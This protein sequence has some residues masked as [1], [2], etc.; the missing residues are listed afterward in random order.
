LAMLSAIARMTDFREEWVRGGDVIS[1]VGVGWKGGRKAAG[2]GALQVDSGRRE[3]NASS[4]RR[5]TM[6]GQFAHF[7]HETI[8]DA[9]KKC[10]I[11]TSLAVQRAQSCKNDQDGVFEGVSDPA[12]HRCSQNRRYQ[13]RRQ[14][15]TDQYRQ[16]ATDAVS[17]GHTVSLRSVHAG[18]R[19]K[20]D[21]KRG[22]AYQGPGTSAT[23]DRYESSDSRKV[24]NAEPRAH[25]Q[26][27]GWRICPPGS[28][29]CSC[30]GSEKVLARVVVDNETTCRMPT[31]RMPR[32]S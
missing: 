14:P 31:C 26:R 21:L 8:S 1:G 29:R 6:S 15:G 20:L 2:A 19:P 13:R 9:P 32:S 22:A 17:K 4:A 23:G 27:T 30:F 3:I 5:A 10:E 25:V 7:S 28:I 16:R 12:R 18:C 24:P 11:V